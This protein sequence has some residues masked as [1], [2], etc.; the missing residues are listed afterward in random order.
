MEQSSQALSPAGLA[1]TDPL[2]ADEWCAHS[3]PTDVSSRTQNTPVSEAPSSAPAAVRDHRPHTRVNTPTTD[4]TDNYRSLLS[5]PDS[6][7]NVT[8]ARYIPLSELSCTFT[9]PDAGPIYTY[10]S[11][12]PPMRPPMDAYNPGSGWNYPPQSIQYTIPT[13]TQPN[14]QTQ[15]GAP[16]TS[17]FAPG[18]TWQ[19]TRI[20]DNFPTPQ[21]TPPAST[22]WYLSNPIPTVQIS[23]YYVLHPCLNLPPPCNYCGA[24]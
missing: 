14:S 19:Y 21:H 10:N 18:L 4:T 1:F 16:A 2:I 11:R 17:C 5:E 3:A 15:Q 20:W 12:D 6:R 23:P 7:P 13:D 8:P 9:E 24:A 22:G